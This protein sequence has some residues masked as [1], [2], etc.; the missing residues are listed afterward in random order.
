MSRN[1][2]T[3]IAVTACLATSAQA[4]STAELS[5]TRVFYGDLDLSK[6]AGMQTLMGR[7]KAASRQVC[8]SSRGELRSTANGPEQC[9][10]DAVSNALAAISKA[11]NRVLANNAD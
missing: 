1:L 9:A 4:Q 2:F 7:L 11:Q 5:S 10:Q 6:P 8:G 3:V